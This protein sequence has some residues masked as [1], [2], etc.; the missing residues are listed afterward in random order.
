MASARAADPAPVCFQTYG[1]QKIFEWS[2]K[3]VER[4]VPAATSSAPAT[5]THAGTNV[6]TMI[7]HL[8]NLNCS[9][10]DSMAS[11]GRDPRD[12]PA[13]IA[14]GSLGWPVLSDFIS[15][16][17]RVL[18]NFK[19]RGKHRNFCGKGKPDD[20]SIDNLNSNML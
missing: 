4:S 7:K 20:G 17:S 16:F 11:L 5:A 10:N 15:P 12:L 3:Q 18:A 19:G 9:N 14:N 6:N 13:I 1:A 2:Q 8:N